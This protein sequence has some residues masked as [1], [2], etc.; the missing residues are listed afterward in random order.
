MKKGPSNVTDATASTANTTKGKITRIPAYTEDDDINI[1]NSNN[2]TSKNEED[3]V[4]SVVL[5]NGKYNYYHYKIDG[6]NDDGWGCAYRSLQTILS[7]F[8][9]AGY[10]K[11]SIP[12][13]SSIQKILS[14]VDSDKSQKKSFIGSHEWIGSYEI[15]LVLQ[16]YMTTLECTIQHIDSGAALDT[17]ISLQHLLQT[18]FA[19]A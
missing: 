15:M 17:D 8:Q 5:V 14:I 4:K 16:Y 10:I 11:E 3:N 1:K 9:Y 6:Y 2:Y 7:W 13:I 12:T 19:S 18:H